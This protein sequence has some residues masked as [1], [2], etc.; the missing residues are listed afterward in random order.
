MYRAGIRLYLHLIALQLALEAG[1]L[2]AHA[3]VPTGLDDDRVLRSSTAA[4]LEQIATALSVEPEDV[5]PSTHTMSEPSPLP[6]CGGEGPDL[7]VRDAVLNEAPL[8]RII[9]AAALQTARGLRS[10]GATLSSAYEALL[11]YTPSYTSRFSLEQ[12][13]EH[14]KRHGSFYTKPPLARA[15]VEAS[16]LPIRAR[17]E[18]RPCALRVLDPAMGTGVFLLEAVHA[19][20]RAGAGTAAELAESC[21]YGY[22]VDPL[23][24]EAA[25][26]SLWL[27]T[28]ARPP[29]LAHHLRRLDPVRS[30]SPVRRERFD[31]V[32]GNPP[33]GATY[34]PAERK[35]LA[36]RW[37]LSS[38]GSFD[39]F[40]HFLELAA[41]QSHGTIGMIVPRAVLSQ[42]THAGVRAL[43]LRRFAPYEVR[44][45]DADEFPRAVAP[46]C[47]LIFGPRPGPAMIACRADRTERRVLPSGGGVPARCWTPDRF[48][49]SDG[50]LLDLLDRLCL[51]HPR[52]AELGSIYRVRDAGI[53]YSR[54][55]IARRILYEGELPE[56]PRDLPRYRGR[57]FARYGAVARGG[58]L[59]HDARLRLQPGER[60][61]LDHETYRLPAK[62]VFRQTADRI[63]ATLDRTCMA[64]GRSVIAVTAEDDAALLPLLA[65]L[66]SS[67]A[68]RLYRA[69]AGEEGRVLPQV[70]VKT[71]CLLPLPNACL[72]G[73]RNAT[74]V[75]L[76]EMARRRL[77]HPRDDA[78]LDGEIDRAVCALFGLS[79][80]ETAIIET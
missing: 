63:T 45:L 51:Q 44:I 7:L 62:I 30:A 52:L 55:A 25:V 79:V 58:W 70:K 27:E 8:L 54:A 57:N 67:L 34:T 14:A 49:L 53:N 6:L 48:P 41:Q 31:L 9:L 40:K 76:G 37:R 46:A 39:S 12:S 77:T 11:A 35:A 33:W 4:G 78:I 15:M 1:R 3:A 80:G 50:A 66:N 69:L 23:A 38:S 56:H 22:D 65:C 20:V 17:L 74:W 43:L 73:T 68:T 42:S 64:L 21:V 61:Y 24:V 16:L 5:P 19:L 60:L 26:L 75:A 18:R 2:P 13:A 36:E 32:I 47:G 59:R 71:L 29:I 72:D 28:G 10:P